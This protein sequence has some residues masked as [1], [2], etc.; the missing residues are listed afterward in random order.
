[1]ADDKLNLTES[2]KEITV[3][4]GD[5]TE[6]IKIPMIG[7][8]T[9][10]L[11][12]T[13]TEKAVSDALDAGYV[14]IDT[15]QGY[16]NEEYV[17]RAIQR[18]LAGG[19]ARDKI[20]ISSKLNPGTAQSDAELGPMTE[21]DAEREKAR[22]RTEVEKSF[23]ALGLTGE[24]DYIDCYYIH[25]PAP[26]NEM[27]NGHE[28]EYMNSVL[29]Q[30]QVL[31]EYYQAGKIKTIGVSN[32]SIQ[33]LNRLKEICELEH[34]QMPQ[35][36]QMPLLIG[37]NEEERVR[38]CTE[39]NI[40]PVA[41]SILGSKHLLDHELV[42]AMASK[43]G[44][45][46]A[47]LC[48]YYT[49]QVLKVPSLT[50]STNPERIRANSQVP[51]VP[52]SE[53]DTRIL[54]ACNDDCRE[55]DV[56]MGWHHDSEGRF[57]DTPF[58]QE[59][60]DATRDGVGGLNVLDLLPFADL[61]YDTLEASRPEI[62]AEYNATAQRFVDTFGSLDLNTL[63]EVIMHLTPSKALL[64]D[65][66][67]H[68]FRDER[69]NLT[70]WLQ[71]ALITRLV[72]E[73]S[74]IPMETANKIYELGW[75]E[76][77]LHDLE[78]WRADERFASNPVIT[79]LMTTFENDTPPINMEHATE[80]T[81]RRE[82]TVTTTT[83]IIEPERISGNL[84]YKNG[85]LSYIF[86][87]YK[88]I[89]N[90][91]SHLVLIQQ[92][93]NL[94]LNIKG[95][96]ELDRTQNTTCQIF[97][98]SFATVEGREILSLELE[99]NGRKRNVNF[100]IPKERNEQLLT[101]LNTLLAHTNITHT[102]IEVF[103]CPR[104]T[105]P[106]F[107]KRLNPD[108]PLTGEL[109]EEDK[110][111]RSKR[112][113][114][115]L[116]AH[117][118]T[119][120]G[121][122]ISGLSQEIEIQKLGLDSSQK[123]TVFDSSSYT[124]TSNSILKDSLLIVT[125]DNKTTPLAAFTKGTKT[126]DGREIPTIQFK[127]SKEFLDDFRSQ[128]PDV[129]IPDG[130]TEGNYIVYEVDKLKLS[131]DLNI[132]DIQIRGASSDF[133]VLFSALG[134]QIVDKNK[135]FGMVR[136]DEKP[137]NIG[138]TT[139][140]LSTVLKQETEK[141][142]IEKNC[143]YDK[144]GIG[145]EALLIA[146]IQ[147]ERNKSPNPNEI[148]TVFLPEGADHPEEILYSVPIKVKNED[149][150][151]S[152]QFLNIRT[153]N[154]GKSYAYLHITGESVKSVKIPKFYEIDIAHIEESANSTFDSPENP[155][156]YLGLKDGKDVVRINIGID[157]EEN[158]NVL[159]ALKT[160]ILENEFKR[161]IENEEIATPLFDGKPRI[162]G[163]EPLMTY[164]I[165]K[166]RSANISSFDGIAIYD[167]KLNPAE[168][169]PV[170][171]RAPDLPDFPI[172][173]RERVVTVID[174][175]GNGDDPSPP[176]P[177]QPPQPP[178]PGDPGPRRPQ[179]IAWKEKLE[180]SKPPKKN[181]IRNML[182]GLFALCTLLSVLVPWL[183]I[184]AIIFAGIEVGR[185]VK[186]WI[187][188]LN[189]SASHKSKERKIRE[190]IRK[191]NKKLTKQRDKLNNLNQKR[192]RILNNPTLSEAK[193]RRQ[194]AKIDA[195]VRRSRIKIEKL[196]IDHGNQELRLQVLNAN[197]AIAEARETL[198]NARKRDSQIRKAEEADLSE[199][200][201]TRDKRQRDINQASKRRDKLIAERDELIRETSELEELEAKDESLLTPEE[202][203][204]LKKL[205]KKLNRNRKR[206][207]TSENY[208]SQIENCTNA[209]ENLTTERDRAQS[210]LDE[211][212]NETDE[213]RVQRSNDLRDMESNSSELQHAKQEIIRMIRDAKNNKKHATGESVEIN[214]TDGLE[215]FELEPEHEERESELSNEERAMIRARRTSRSRLTGDEGRG[216][217]AG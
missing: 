103:N 160:N 101:A 73:N 163:G 169:E 38:F 201:K 106:I 5:S 23:A 47:E 130:S 80:H 213:N 190:K 53:L 49:T 41:Y 81:D 98:T 181:G 171:T 51:N 54:S 168:K 194:L 193:R 12:D 18:A 197:T 123:L 131:Q 143:L 42:K 139:D 102:E 89:D 44:M 107:D 19:L 88:T 138:V 205:R 31:N 76:S 144:K 198:K 120:D 156:L 34:L 148:V 216:R 105:N 113:A 178:Q 175:G 82:P 164:A 128:N 170:L 20:F 132:N 61:D 154:S 37:H 176:P 68:D 214:E 40:Q 119:I 79:S 56:R 48:T 39:N 187:K 74:P 204:R 62:Y 52:L 115:S 99:V 137:F 110:L 189:F 167:R 7:Q 145:Y 57:L 64:L 63:N 24:H 55:W 72:E 28:S 196:Q 27:E 95:F 206:S 4:R 157:F 177:P 203:K 134:C 97:S 129:E 58:G 114:Q 16:G 182:I 9:W 65:N 149:G 152:Q 155:S 136:N 100:P 92:G 211:L 183:A 166:E 141:T 200:R 96:N 208:N 46:P 91:D 186:P 112:K 59:Q 22:I 207:R 125:S 173:N 153:D 127:V 67:R 111:V 179:P 158:A 11:D 210:N 90:S 94:Y 25:S 108:V 147:L 104:V 69:T 215:D 83:E 6:T 30:W 124:S 109:T 21:A 78:I 116:Q 140:F 161:T 212:Q 135:H 202:K 50:R 191:I 87:P 71:T 217:D 159:R 10:M 118:L 85:E 3:T 199:L 2:F 180:K 35:V 17:G 151:T 126:E 43:Y 162:I 174:D 1:M 192:Q 60:I 117:N 121:E 209:I 184:A 45:T 122:T 77:F 75:R 195:K 70:G 29:L 185:E 14:A 146:R 142:D 133:A 33:A 172:V 66:C 8:G 13:N 86:L 188:S 150:S 165:P 36:M 84:I 32:F 93:E 15:A 26:W